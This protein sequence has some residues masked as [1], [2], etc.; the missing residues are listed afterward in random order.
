MF[1]HSPDKS[2]DEEIRGVDS[3]RVKQE[4]LVQAKVDEV[5]GIK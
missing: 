5:L 1:N 3:L 2:V 4:R